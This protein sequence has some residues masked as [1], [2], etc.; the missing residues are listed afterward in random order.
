[1]MHELVRIY[2][3]ALSFIVASKKSTFTYMESIDIG[4]SIGLVIF[5]L[6]S[7]DLMDI[8]VAQ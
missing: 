7:F 8:V 4:L 3:N 6:Q 1:M 5:N 2:T